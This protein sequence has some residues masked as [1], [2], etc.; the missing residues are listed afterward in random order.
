M[1]AR[2]TSTAQPRRR[3]I[4]AFVAAVAAVATVAIAAPSHAAVVTTTIDGITYK[5]D[6]AN[7]AAGATITNYDDAAGTVVNIPASIELAGQTYAVTAIGDQGFYKNTLTDVTIPDSVTSIGSLAFRL[8]GLESVS[9]GANVQSIGFAAFGDN[10]LTTLTIPDSVQTIG[11][12]AFTSNDLTEVT[13]GNGVTSISDQAFTNNNLTT[14]TLGTSLTTI[15]NLAFFM[16]SITSV[17]IPDSVTTIGNLAFR[18]NELTSVTLGDNVQTI[19]EYAF[20]DSNLTQVTIPASVAN[21]GTAA[22]RANPLEAVTFE[23]DAPST[24]SQPFGTITSINDPLVSYSADAVGFSAPLWL[25]GAVNY[26]TQAV[27]T[28]TF[29]AG[30]AGTAPAQQQVIVGNLAAEPDALTAEGYTF[31]GWF[32]TDART[33]VFDFAAAITGSTTVFAQWVE[34]PAPV[35]EEEEVPVV[36]EEEVPVEEV[37]VEEVPVDEVVTADEVLSA[38]ALESGTGTSAAATGGTLAETGAETTGLA[39]IAALLIGLGTALTMRARRH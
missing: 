35:V 29:D 1:T 33:E 21:I 37:P 19:G 5:V 9:I 31:M 32:S 25:A 16:N 28:V 36:E 3:A 13:I 18:F 14:V 12:Q 27:A 39:A 34:V 2:H 26:R 17:T 15:G 22:F 11:V 8:T 4:R 30:I 20:A 23:G 6:N 38:G 24:V 7:V 10:A